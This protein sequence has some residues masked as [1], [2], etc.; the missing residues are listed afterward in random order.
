M[1]NGRV[2]EEKVF[3]NVKVKVNVNENGN[4]NRNVPLY[5]RRHEKPGTSL[6]WKHVQKV[7]TLFR[8][9]WFHS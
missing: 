5:V 9:S 6:F 7:R 3:V 4:M 2:C 1:F 8:F